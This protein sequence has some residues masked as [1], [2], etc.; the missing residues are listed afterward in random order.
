MFN[1]IL[2]DTRYVI[3]TLYSRC[4]LVEG[5][6]YFLGVTGVLLDPICILFSCIRMHCGISLLTVTD[7]GNIWDSSPIIP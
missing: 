2:T 5:R 1:F 3:R 6:E 7:D 4:P